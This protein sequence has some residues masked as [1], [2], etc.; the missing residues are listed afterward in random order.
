MYES[1]GE[2]WQRA[3][4]I[5]AELQSTRSLP[6][7]ACFRF[8][9]SLLVVDCEDCS[10]SRRFLEIFAE[11]LCDSTGDE[12]IP[13]L[14]LQITRVRS[15]PTLLGA[16]LAPSPLDGADFVPQLFP[17]GQYVECLG[18]APGWR[19]LALREV[20]SQPV[21]AFGPSTVLISRTHPWQRMIALYAISNAF[22]L[23][24]DIFV[25]HAASIAVNGKGI[26]LFGSKGAGKTTL[27]L[28]LASR[29]HAFLGDEWG[30]VSTSTGELFPLRR[31]ASIRPGPRA[32]R[33]DEFLENHSCEAEVLPDGTRRVKA[34][35]GA[36]FP[37]AAAQIVP[38][39][40]AFFLR[41][42]ASRPTVRRFTLDGSGLPPISPLLATMWGHSPG[43]RTLDLL[44]TLGR[45]SWWHLDVGGSPDETA[46]LIEKTVREDTYGTD[47]A[48]ES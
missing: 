1:C 25:F 36:L 40:H 23:Q 18:S 19:M 20:A 44:R 7:K 16:S 21:L 27:S 14:D 9:R 2:W 6:H 11:C 12:D 41:P 46:D 13:R 42:F 47:S 26:L 37:Q 17:E 4:V 34:K 48:R 24:P 33:V 32:K 31:M 5:A 43:Q 30:A 39:T 35:V 22:R 15:N 45:S 28:C 8:G 3:D 10:F 38:L 29:G